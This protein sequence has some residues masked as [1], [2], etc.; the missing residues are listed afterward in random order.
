MTTKRIHIFVS[1]RVQGVFFRLFVRKHAKQLNIKGWV[2]NLSN[3]KVEIIADGEE[4]NLNQLI[5]LCKEGP[6]FAKVD[7]IEVQK[8]NSTGKFDDFKIT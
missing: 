1:G 5:I 2:K 7:Y 8:E 6:R 3:G 4:L